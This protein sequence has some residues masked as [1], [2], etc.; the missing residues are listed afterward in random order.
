MEKNKKVAP[1]TGAIPNYSCITNNTIDSH[2]LQ[3]LII[4][5]TS[6]GI[7]PVTETVICEYDEIIRFRVQ[8]DKHGSKNG[9]CI[10]FPSGN[11]VFG[12]WK[13]G[14]TA[15]WSAN[16]S[17]SLNKKERKIF[18]EKLKKDKVKRDVSLQRL[19]KNTAIKCA[20]LWSKSSSIKRNHPY[21][22][23]KNINANGARLLGGNLLLPIQNACGEL[24]NLQTITTTGI[25]RFQFGGAV[26]GCFMVLGELK[27]FIYIVEGFSTGAT[28]RQVT[29]CNVVV[30]FNAGN[31][32]P[33]SK[34]LHAT[35]PNFQLVV[36][37]DNDCFSYKNT[38][39]DAAKSVMQELNLPVVYPRFVIGQF[40]SDF[41]DLAKIC[42]NEVVLEQLSEQLREFIHV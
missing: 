34:I 25:K 38:G 11:G 5:M 3:G 27:G 32:L 36:A 26:K 2:F 12:S 19:Q 7:L 24:V 17:Q 15:S 41:N 42:G 23:D 16:Q 14:I 4:A 37:S 9:W 8:G 35:N 40:G 20:E 33:V 28:V 13:L 22:L 39:L 10:V 30:A 31:L 21:L 1:G 29:G 6:H 18:F